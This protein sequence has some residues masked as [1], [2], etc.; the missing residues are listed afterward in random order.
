MSDYFYA[1]SPLHS[2]IFVFLTE[3]ERAEWVE[4]TDGFTV[5]ARRIEPELRAE[6]QE[7]AAKRLAS[8][9]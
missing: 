1:A 4:A 2:G 9:A 6:L 3:D 7:L 5:S 8:R